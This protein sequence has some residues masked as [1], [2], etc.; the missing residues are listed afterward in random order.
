MVIF[1]LFTCPVTSKRDNQKQT[2]MKK[3]K[4]EIAVRG[5]VICNLFDPPLKK[6]AFHAKV[7]A[8]QI[9]M[10]GDLRGYYLLNATR[11]RNGFPEIDIQAYRE[12]KKEESQA[13]RDR[14]LR[15]VAMLCIDENITPLLPYVDF[16]ESLDNAD[17]EIVRECIKALK[18]SYDAV[19]TDLKRLAV[20]RGW[21]D[22][23][24]RFN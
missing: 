24:D 15:H 6:T 2:D 9:A 10:A 17:I 3:P 16:P 23:I 8:G 21:V 5:E 4:D 14:L 20:F 1:N 22:G 19:D 18:P 7:N 12:S 13:D 11:L